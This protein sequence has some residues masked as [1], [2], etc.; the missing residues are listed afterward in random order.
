MVGYLVREEGFV[1][2]KIGVLSMLLLLSTCQSDAMQNQYN[3]EMEPYDF[4]KKYTLEQCITRLLNR[5]EN[6]KKLIYKKQVD[7]KFLTQFF[8]KALNIITTGIY[9]ISVD[10]QLSYDAVKILKN[11]SFGIHIYSS[12]PKMCSSFSHSIYFLVCETRVSP[13]SCDYA[14]Y[15]KNVATILLNIEKHVTNK[16]YLK[17]MQVQK[18]YIKNEMRNAMSPDDYLQAWFYG[19][20]IGIPKL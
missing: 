2:N 11:L 9:E 5:S 12:F 7:L 3:F 17:R 14:E 10:E 18:E 15:L 6:F 20:L 4:G 8:L 1:M 13:K 19:L 16:V